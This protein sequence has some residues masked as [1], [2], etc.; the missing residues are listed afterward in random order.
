[1]IEDMMGKIEMNDKIVWERSVKLL[2]QLF[3]FIHQF[4]LIGFSTFMV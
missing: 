4:L 1:M 2:M 3:Y